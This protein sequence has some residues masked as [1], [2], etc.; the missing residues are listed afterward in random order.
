MGLL[1]NHLRRRH[2]FLAPR[3]GGRRLAH[4]LTRRFVLAY[5]RVDDLAQKPV[6]GPGQVFDLDDELRPDPMHPRQHQRRAKPGRAWRR[7][8]ER[9]PVGLE[10]LQPPQEV[11]DLVGAHPGADPAGI[12]QPPVGVVVP[13]QQRA[14]ERPAALGVGPADND[15]FLPVE[16]FGLSQSPR[17]PGL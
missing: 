8:I 16:A 1:P 11:L 13:E 6:F 4:D 15:K 2:R 14:D 7:D 12:N 10:R 3:T 17:W 9:H 5:P